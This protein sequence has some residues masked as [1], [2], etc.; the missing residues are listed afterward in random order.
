MSKL[1]TINEFFFDEIDTEAKA[2]ILGFIYADGC[3][4]QHPSTLA[5]SIAQLEQD[6]DILYQI[7]EKMNSTY[8]IIEHIQK[9][10]G[11]K[12]L[13]FYAYNQTLCQKLMGLGV[14][15][16]K[17]L[18]LKFPYFIKE[19][20]MRHFIRGYFD[21]DGCIW[22]GKRKKMIVKDKTV[23]N[24]IRERIIHN[25][26]FTF[27]GCKSFIEPLQTWFIQHI[28]LS[29]TKL[30][31]SKANNPNN[32]TTENVCTME[33]SGRANIK[34]LYDYMYADASIYGKRKFDKFNEILCAFNEKSLNDIK[35]TA[36]KP[37]LQTN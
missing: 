16:R 12:I 35:L 31:F 3:V 4:Y 6:G 20:L 30:N 19:E 36:G 27:T 22:N 17:S 28:G 13:T 25:V 1:H 7:K 15:K 14:I 5:L 11:K 21:G 29:T 18:L 34:K 32:S 37:T 24:G 9:G 23:T 26:K 8:P 33:Y 10:N 2:Y